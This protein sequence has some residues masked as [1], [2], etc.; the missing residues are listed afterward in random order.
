VNGLR[1]RCES[2]PFTVAVDKL[3][4]RRQGLEAMT[5]ALTRIPS[6]PFVRPATACALFILV[7]IVILP[8]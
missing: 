6:L 5:T 3:R 1:G 4:K 2:G 7:I 8:L